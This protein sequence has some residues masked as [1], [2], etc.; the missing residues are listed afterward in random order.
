MNRLKK[1]KDLQLQLNTKKSVQEKLFGV[2]RFLYVGIFLLIVGTILIV[3]I[4]PSLLDYV[5]KFEDVGI[6]VAI[7]FVCV[8]VLNILY[9]LNRT[10]S[11]ILEQTNWVFLMM[12]SILGTFSLFII[13]M[14]LMKYLNPKVYDSLNLANGTTNLISLSFDLAGIVLA[15]FALTVAAMGY[16]FRNKLVEVTSQAKTIKEYYDQIFQNTIATAQL[17]F[18]DIPREWM[19]T[20]IP[21][22]LKRVLYSVLK[23]IKREEIK[24]F[25]SKSGNTVTLN[26]AQGLYL[27]VEDRI[28]ESIE[29]LEDTLKMIHDI[30]RSIQNESDNKQLD[31]IRESILYRLGICYRQNGQLDNSIRVFDELI[32]FEGKKGKHYPK[33]DRSIGQVGKAISLFKKVKKN[34]RQGENDEECLKY[35]EECYGIMKKQYTVQKIN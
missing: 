8:C 3:F 26:F 13:T 5:D 22:R 21:E 16:Y 18:G 20:Q 27:F 24:E 1:S 25:I 30:A 29:Q 28:S 11:G 17:L 15:F 9:I 33:S 31:K 2:I 10:P 32:E 34:V 6:I 35:L 4:N 12:V 19:T 7:V 23:Y 14:F